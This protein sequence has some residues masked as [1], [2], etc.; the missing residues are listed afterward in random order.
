VP[1]WRCSFLTHLSGESSLATVSMLPYPA[2]HC[3]LGFQEGNFREFF[4]HALG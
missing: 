2:L 1:T 4:F 3:A